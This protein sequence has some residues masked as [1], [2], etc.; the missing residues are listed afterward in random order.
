[1]GRASRSLALLA[2]VGAA[3]VAAASVS[4]QGP[5]IVNE[6]MHFA[7]EVEVFVD[8]NPCKPEPSG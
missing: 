8:V 1:M 4:A 7:D 6:T 2:S 5:P 3:L